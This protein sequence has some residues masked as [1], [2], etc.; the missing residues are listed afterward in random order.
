MKSGYVPLSEI[1][2]GRVDAE[3]EVTLEAGRYFDRVYQD[4]FQADSNIR[5][6]KFIVHGRKGTGKS[7]IACYLQRSSSPNTFVQKLEYSMKDLEQIVQAPSISEPSASQ[8]Q[9]LWTWIF[10]CAMGKFLL[11][12]Q[13]IN[14][15]TNMREEFERFYK[16][17]QGYCSPGSLE[18]QK[19]IETE[20]LDIRITALNRLLDAKGIVQVEHT[21]GRANFLK[22][23]NPLQQLLKDVFLSCKRDIANE[24]FI[25]IDNLDTGYVGNHIQKNALLGILRAAKLLYSSFHEIG[26][27]LFPVVLIRTDMLEDLMSEADTNKLK[28]ANGLR[29]N[30]YDHDTYLGDERRVP[31]RNLISSRIK[32]SYRVAGISVDDGWEC[33]FRNWNH[34]KPSFKYLIDKTLYRPRDLICLFNLVKDASPKK[35]SVTREMIDRVSKSF[36]A[37]MADE[38]KN[39]LGAH[40][41]ASTL[42]ALFDSLKEVASGGGRFT[43]GN[44]AA[45]L[46]KSAVDA[47]KMLDMAFCYGLICAYPGGRTVWSHR[48]GPD[49]EDLDLASGVE[50][51]VHFAFFDHFVKPKQRPFW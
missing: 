19:Q 47:Q 36:A 26:V 13:S 6:G 41:D 40:C 22:I 4:P 38:W 15:P 3:T 23:L 16:L 31:L 49:L 10:L 51:G 30:W 1:N 24:Y 25:L 18:L 29:L 45:A 5:S 34:D 27:R 20:K 43:I 46:G 39:E 35:D 50:M 12:D 21:Q 9:A 33:L 37:Y 2:F 17:N 14:L 42:Q 11:E 7:A 28:V 48:P 8:S 44:Y 32:D